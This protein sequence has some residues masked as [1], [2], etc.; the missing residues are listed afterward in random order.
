MLDLRIP[1]GLFFLLV[2]VILV[3]MGLLSPL[4]RAALTQINVNLYCGL[5]M[6]SFGAGLLLLARRGTRG[7]S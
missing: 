2:G 6:L 7:R 1:T 5:I 4:E 3:A